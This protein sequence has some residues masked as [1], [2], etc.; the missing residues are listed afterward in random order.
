MFALTLIK[1]ACVLPGL[2]AA[3]YGY[4]WVG[5]TKKTKPENKTALFFSSFIGTA[6]CALSVVY[7]IA[8]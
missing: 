7:A 2:L 8:L 5:S 3:A 4:S 6:A 1:I